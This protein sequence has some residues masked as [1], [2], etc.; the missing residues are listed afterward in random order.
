MRARWFTRARAAVRRYPELVRMECDLRTGKITP[1]YNGMPSSLSASRKTEQLALRELPR[2]DRRDLE[3]VSMA[4]NTLDE[5]YSRNKDLRKIIIDLY[6]WKQ[7]H[8]IE[9]AAMKVHVSPDT[10]RTWDREF[11]GLVDAYRRR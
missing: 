10:A 1:T 3:A 9:G 2:Q 4:L 6:Y 7:S 5:R 11:I 8:T